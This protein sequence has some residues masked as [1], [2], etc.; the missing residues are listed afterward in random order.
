MADGSRLKGLLSICPRYIIV[1]PNPPGGIAFCLAGNIQDWEHM[2]E[3]HDGISNCKPG[4][5]KAEVKA[6]EGAERGFNDREACLR[7]VAEL[8]DETELDF[9]ITPDEWQAWEQMFKDKFN[10]AV[11]WDEGIT[12][13]FAGTFDN[14]GLHF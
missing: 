8:N 9:T 13:K 1:P 11:E 7:W 3:W 12:W 6:I 14:K 5:W 2:F 4:I 10:D